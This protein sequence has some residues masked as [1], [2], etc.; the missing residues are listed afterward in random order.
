MLEAFDTF[1]PSGILEKV[2]A[3]VNC[4]LAAQN[5]KLATIQEIRG[6]IVLHT[7][8]ASYSSSV[9]T[10]T[11]ASNADFFFQLGIDGKHY[12]QIWNALSC[13]NDRRHRVE[14]SS[15][16]WSNRPSRGNALITELEQE[17]AAINRLLVYVPRAT[18]FSLDDDH[19]R[20]SSR[21]VT[22]LTTF[23]KLTTRR[24]R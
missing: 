23:P 8:A 4:V 13:T 1:L 20:L 2:K 3:N 6:V 9:S 21:A 11:S 10:I 14:Y 16:G 18:I 24:R 5:Q 22:Q 17:F 19:Q 15:T 7:L 12:L